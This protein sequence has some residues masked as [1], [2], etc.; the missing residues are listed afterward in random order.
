MTIL[1]SNF[2]EWERKNPTADYRDFK[3]SIDKMGKSG[4]LFDIDKLNDVSK[5][6]LAT[7]TE[8]ETYD[9]L[10]GWVDEFGTEQDKK[11]FEDKEYIKKIIVLICGIGGK[12][13]RRRE[14]F[15]VAD[16]HGALC[17]RQRTHRLRR[18]HLRRL[19][20]NNEVEQSALRF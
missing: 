3:F 16:D 18:G 14:L 13:R 7:L 9:F 2:E 12:K 6:E 19:V 1:N 15:G 8:D 10:K 5:A 17:P 4:A 20:E 11:H